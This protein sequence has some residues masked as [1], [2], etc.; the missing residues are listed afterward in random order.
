MEP[1]IGQLALFGFDFVPTGWM[2]CEGQLLQIA[3]YQALYALLGT[4]FGGNGT[5]TFALPDLRGR[6]ALDAG[7]LAGGSS[8][9]LGQAGGRE[10]VTLTPDNLPAHVHLIQATTTAANTNRPAG[11][12]LADPGAQGPAMYA[13]Q[14]GPSPEML[15]PA[16]VAPAGAGQ[17]HTNMQPYLALTW[18]IA[19][20]GVWPSRD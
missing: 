4:T 12:L 5:T 18:A 8:Y 10:V 7:Q 9:P 20:Q 13:P 17:P 2:R 15:A 11:N 19:I 14:L 6:A 3:Q 16:A 1:F